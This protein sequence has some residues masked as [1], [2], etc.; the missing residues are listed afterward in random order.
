MINEVV[1]FNIVKLMNNKQLSFSEIY[2]KKFFGHPSNLYKYIKG[3][4]P[5]SLTKL[6]QFCIVLKCSY[7]DLVDTKEYTKNK[8]NN[9]L[10]FNLMYRYKK[11]TLQGYNE[12]FK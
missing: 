1:R 4:R 2:N 8:N 5:I 6:E 11:N 10:N 7:K 9:N 12:R 3:M